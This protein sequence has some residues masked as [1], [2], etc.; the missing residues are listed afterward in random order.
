V[1][2]L[3]NVERNLEAIDEVKCLTS[4]VKKFPNIKM[5]DKKAKLLW[6]HEQRRDTN[7]ATELDGV[8]EEDKDTNAMNMVVSLIMET[9]YTKFRSSKAL[10]SL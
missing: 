2:R 10:R 8:V 7:G 1:E 9:I 4:Y 3:Q 6:Q 5:D